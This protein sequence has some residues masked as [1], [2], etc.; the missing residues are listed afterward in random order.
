MERQRVIRSAAPGYPARA[1]LTPALA[2]RL[3]LTV[4]L[5]A[6]PLVACSTIQHVDGLMAYP[7]E[8]WATTLP[9]E[10]SHTVALS[11]GAELAYHLDLEVR[12]VALT[13][14]E[15]RPEE[16]L[17]AADAVLADE[18]AVTFEAEDLTALEAGIAEAFAATC[19]TPVG[20]F[21]TTDLVV[22]DVGS[23]EDTGI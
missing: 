13:C 12:D 16:L 21:V 4:A 10:G 22:D 3:A 1:A 17:A 14:V 8:P 15:E 18:L 19:G 5:A 9:A 20:N 6:V 11:D 7:E 2:R 23:A